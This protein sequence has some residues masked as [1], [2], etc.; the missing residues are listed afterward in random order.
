MQADRWIETIPF[1]ETREYV[2]SILAYTAIYE[3]R[4]GLPQTRLEQVMQNVPSKKSGK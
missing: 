4:M 2:S 1:K 3:H